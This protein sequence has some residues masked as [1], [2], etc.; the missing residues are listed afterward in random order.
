VIK[1]FL[2]AGINFHFMI[3]VA[4]LAVIKDEPFPQEFHEAYP[5]DES[6]RKIIADR[7]QNVWIA[8]VSGIWKKNKNERIWNQVLNRE[9]RGPAFSL[10]SDDKGRIWMG[11]WNAVWCMEGKSLKK[12]N[13]TEG[14]ISVLFNS[15]SGIYA[16]GPMGLWSFNGTSFIKH[17]AIIPK[18][19]R[20]GVSD[21]NGDLWLASDV[22][23]YHVIKDSSIRLSDTS[24]LISAAQKG[25]AFNKEHSLWAAG[26]GG[27][28]IIS[29]GSRIKSLTSAD[30]CPSI[31]VNT[32]SMAP[33]GSM[34]V[35][36]R[37]GIVRYHTDGSHTLRFSRRWLMHD[38]VTS[39]S[40][41]GSGTAWIGTD[42]GVSAIKVRMM[43]FEDK[44]A[45]FYD[46]L[47]RRHIRAPWIAG[48]CKLT[49][50][51]DTISWKPDD[52]DNDGEY[53]GN[54]LAMESFRFA[55]TK[56]NEAKQ[57]ARKAFQFLKFL[58]EVT[59]SK[60]YFARTIVPVDWN[61]TLHDTNR[62]YTS[63]EIADEMVKEPRFKP[64]AERWR[65][66]QDGKW[67]W[68]GDASSDEMCGHMF[69]YFF[70]HELVADKEEKKII[71]KHVA[72][73]V[74]HLIENNYN[75]MDVD[76]SHTR[77][78]VWSP[79][80][81]NRDPEWLPDQYQNSME[82]L[83]FLKLAYY[84]TGNKDYEKRYR[85]LINEEHYLEN[86]SEIKNQNPAW[87][88][89]F[90]VILQAYLF[91]I[92]I[93]CETD[94]K[95]RDFYNKHMDEW[96][97][98]RRSDK[99]PLIN[100]IY[101]YTRNKKVELEASRDMLK[102]TPLDLVSWKVDH[103]NREDVTIVHSPVLDEDQVSELPPASI[104]ATIRWDAN[105]WQAVNGNPSIEREP[106][107]WLLPYWI[108]RYI[109]MIN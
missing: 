109:K 84:V 102:D 38:N 46:V 3:G 24:I 68:K 70:Y 37:S 67:L 53:T 39:I 48:Q 81:L 63:E 36:T 14:P 58:Q 2:L 41:D 104:R 30:G 50:P 85:H 6:V 108:G 11:T 72:S 51:G 60:G 15:P 49:I 101:C 59:G 55:V 64:V 62:T 94:P 106:V 89:Y 27:I 10:A 77:W 12:M 105:P 103:R 97:Q 74:D 76:G 43:T 28:N 98:R 100:F 16:I 87:F 83:S 9:D 90:D 26:L 45:C 5:F 69:G 86:M 95:L 20:D 93:K 44:S 52:D 99:N 40:F 25:V 1:Y 18:S 42:N 96:M 56:N 21:E 92:L 4:Q 7:D 88:I 8:T 17:H 73:I 54:Y 34:W 23:I 29:N 82:L 65:R 75:M 71:A 91:P 107:F 35:G 80:K 47:M 13:G 33:D 31:F 61:G 22:G 79:D 57:N 78:S 19:V 32:V 66:S